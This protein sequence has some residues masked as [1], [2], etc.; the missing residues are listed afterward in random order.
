MPYK[1]DIDILKDNGDGTCTCSVLITNDA[2]EDIG[3]INITEKES[4]LDARI[5]SDVQKAYSKLVIANDIDPAT[6]PNL[7][8]KVFDLD[9]Q[10]NMS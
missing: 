7:G 4:L 8:K 2:G 1:A 9:A 5:K 10:G 3:R 6:R